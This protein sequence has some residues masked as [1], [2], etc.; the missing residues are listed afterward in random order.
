M[1]EGERRLAAIMFTDLV[2]F[3]A[4]AQ[5]DELHA[6]ELLEKHREL[7]RPIFGKYGG[8]EIKT[9]GDAFLLEFGSALEAVQCAIEIQRTHHELNQNANE[10]LLVRIGMH[11]GDVI[12]REG[13]LYGDAV[14]IAS[15]IEPLAKGGEVCL[16]EQVYAQIR[17]KIQYPLAKLESHDLKNVTSQVDVYKVLLPWNRPS[18][19]VHPVGSSQKAVTKVFRKHSVEGT[20][21]PKTIGE[22]ILK[23]TMKNKVAD[24]EVLNEPQIPAFLAKFSEAVDYGRGETFCVVSG[25]QTVRVIVDD[26]NVGN[27]RKALPQR[28]VIS[29][30]D[31]LAEV[32][33]TLSQAALTTPGVIATISTELA[34]KGI[35][36]FEYVHATPN[37]IILVEN[38]DAF[39]TYRAL[40]GLASGKHGTT[41]L[42]DAAG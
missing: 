4:L 7:M 11:I 14:N 5:K 37:V 2:G 35:N 38:K 42:D 26:N 23:L 41:R 13:D 1:T 39:R 8:R 33:V 16:S 17:N 34:R 19:Q 30:I 29:V 21:Q 22:L 40:E 10:D 32:I 36:I 31:G 9:M 18:H 28:N 12:R 15:R 27:L 6:L 24:I 20:G 3:T 25:I